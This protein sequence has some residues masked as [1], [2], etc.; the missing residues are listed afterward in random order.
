MCHNYFP[1]SGCYSSALLT[2]FAKLNV[3]SLSLLLRSYSFSH[4]ESTF[5]NISSVVVLPLV[6]DPSSLLSSLLILALLS[7]SRLKG[8]SALDFLTGTPP[9]LFLLAQ[10]HS[11]FRVITFN[12]LFHSYNVSL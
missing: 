2:V 11:L 12:P 8:S 1:L 9:V 5:A 3:H 10:S 6:L 7:N 4:H